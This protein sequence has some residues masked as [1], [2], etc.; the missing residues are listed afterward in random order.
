[1]DPVRNPYVP[2][3]GASPPELAGRQDLLNETA[4]AIQRTLQGRSARGFVATGLRGVG[5]TVLLARVRDMAKEAGFQT[6]FIE[7]SADRTLAQVLIP[8][9]R[10]MTLALD[11]AGALSTQARRALRVLRSFIHTIRLQHHDLQI[12]LD[13][14]SES[15]TADSGDLDSDLSDLMGALGEAAKA[16]GTGILICLDEIQFLSAR[17]MG[18]LIMALHRTSRDGLP[19]L[20]AGAG[21]PHV[22]ALSGQSRTYAER[23]FDFPQPGP[24]SRDDIADALCLPAEREG[25]TFT[26]AAVDEVFRVTRGYPYFIQEWAWHSWNVA[27]GPDIHPGDVQV[28]TEIAITALDK[29]FFRMRS[30]RLTPREHDYCIAMAELGPGTHRSGEIAARLGMNV[31][32]AAALRTSLIRK[33]LIWSPAFGDTAFTVPLFETYLLRMRDTDARRIDPVISLQPLTEE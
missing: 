30:A 5:K 29:S 24:L 11:R 1:M 20:F 25:V 32:N 4:V 21:L 27:H 8:H 22:V 16:R 9:M 12:E 23:L 13:I 26:E 31:R 17:D 6:C 15:G 28:A 33:G 10:R 18:A 3:A 7:A 14:E 2:G 19:V